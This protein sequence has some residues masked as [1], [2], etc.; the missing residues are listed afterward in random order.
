MEEPFVEVPLGWG[1]RASSETVFAV[2]GLSRR[3]ESEIGDVATVLDLVRVGLGIALVAPSS[4]P[5]FGDLH[6]GT[7][8]AAPSFDVHLVLLRD[9]P[10]K[11]AAQELA[12]LVT[13][14]RPHS[15]S[16]A[17][18]QGTGGPLNALSGLARRRRMDP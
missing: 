15:G 3:V 10:V 8:D 17:S 11:P 7:P 2:C 14:R 4:A 9:R 16:L 13:G 12:D 1:S 6:V 18:R 5:G